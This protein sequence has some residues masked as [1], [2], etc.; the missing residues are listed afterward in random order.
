MKLPIKRKY[1]EAIKVGIKRF[2]WRDAHITFVCEETGET[3]RKDVQG[4][5]VV[6]DQAKVNEKKTDNPGCFEDDALIVFILK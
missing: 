1:F 3:I 5:R 2:E 4:C 6:V